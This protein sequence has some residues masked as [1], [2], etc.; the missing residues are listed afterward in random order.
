MDELRGMFA[1]AGLVRPQQGRWLA[2]VAAGLATRL[3]I[4]AWVVRL[5]L[6]VLVVMGAS[7]LPIYVILWV[8]MPPVGWIPPAR[9]P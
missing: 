1:R 9:T 7:G 2:G 6:L 3:G 8:C 4:D 5:L